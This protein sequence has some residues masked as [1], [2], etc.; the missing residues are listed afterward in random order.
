VGKGAVWA[1]N[2]PC[3]TSPD[4]EVA[5]VANAIEQA[6]PGHVLDVN[7]SRGGVELDIETANAIIEVK[8]NRGEVLSGRLRRMN[9]PAVNP[10]GKPVIGYAPNMSRHAQGGINRVGGI[11]AGGVASTLADLVTA[12]R[13]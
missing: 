7:H 12:L 11:A 10:A 1:H 6:Y 4:P 5:N 8:G 9:D 3:W 2:P 13:P